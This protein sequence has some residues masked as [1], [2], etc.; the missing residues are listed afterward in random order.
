M[1]S[2]A[3]CGNLQQTVLILLLLGTALLQLFVA[4]EDVAGQR[5]LFTVFD[6]VLLM[7]ELFYAKTLLEAREGTD[8]MSSF[9]VEVVFFWILEAG[10]FIYAMAR[11]IHMKMQMRYSLSQESI[12]EGSDNLPDGICFFD[13]YG[14]VRLINKKM[15]SIGMML[16]GKEI[17]TLDE[18]HCA[19][20]CPQP[21]V[22]CLDQEIA[23]YHF[24]DG[25]VHRFTESAI[26]DRDGKQITEV[27]AADVT[28]L[29]AK[30][31]EL[32]CEN[33]R[34]ADANRRMKWIL[35]NMSDIVREEE[36]LSMKIRVHD[37]IGHSIL[38][39]KKALIQ[40][41]DITVI[42]ENAVLWETAV[43]LLYRANNMPAV[44]DEWQTV[45]N[46]AKELGVE[47]IF[48]GSLPE[49]EF[50]RHLLLLAIR[51]C[52]TNCVRHAGGNR[53]FVKAADDG[54]QTSYAITN[55]GRVPQQA[56][57]EGSGLS[58]LRC[59]IEREGGSME[60]T[61]SPRFVL[62]VTLPAREI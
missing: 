34:L 47:I 5:Y 6:S 41:Q 26:A 25:A 36:T 16:F 44:E 52:V 32:N 49:D 19:L 43:D 48:D 51:E 46:R 53:V 27:I 50:V 17:Q 39:A 21:G 54:K 30:Q 57:V 38:A 2:F 45:R 14:T 3:A 60:L 22:E 56:V 58:G 7:A 10:L 15:M 12:K 61:D 40:Q 42:R 23:L 62:T 1:S 18:L 55:N 59:R 35:D 4:I 24:P 9:A 13:E 37:D 20:S 29:Y 11:Y 8:S 33:I 31:E 28:E